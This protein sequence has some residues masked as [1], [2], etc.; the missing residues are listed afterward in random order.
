MREREE[1]AV[2]RISSSRARV[3]LG[4]LDQPQHWRATPDRR[5]R[6]VESVLQGSRFAFDVEVAYGDLDH[7]SPVS[8]RPPLREYLRDLWRRR[9]FIWRESRGRF[10]TQNAND[11]LGGFW[12]IARP[13]LDG[14]F[15]WIVFGLV[16]RMSQSIDNYVAFVL[17][18]TM[19]FQF[20][21]RV[22]SASTGVMRSSR[23]LIRA[24]AFP[25]ASIP[26]ALVVRELL[27]ALPGMAVCLVMIAV[28]PPF[29]P[30]RLTW[31]LVPAVFALQTLLG[32]GLALVLARFGSDLPD[33]ANVTGFVLR[34]LMY[35]SGVLF[36]I[37]RFVTDPTALLV[38]QLNPVH[39]ML[40]IYRDLLM[41]GVL[42]QTVD[43][44][45]LAGWGVGL[46]LIGFVYFWRGEETYA[47]QQ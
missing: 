38:V 13:V 42:P 45:V 4:S 8:L 3:Q 19:M 12:L 23:A 41:G 9:H 31:L 46:T 39:A 15:Y 6:A 14:L 24:F 36:P 27:S 47:R 5:E 16:L 29:E 37:D 28:I 18:G 20:T 21:S 22:I 26:L 40:R 11:R 17:I 32:V 7:L 1:T 33:V 10:A 44:V 35:A 34:V 43:V 2:E 25:R 30:P